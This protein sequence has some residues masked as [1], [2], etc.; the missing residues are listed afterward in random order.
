M[1]NLDL[2]VLRSFVTGL[3]LGSFAKAAGRLGRSTSAISAQLK[4]L[5]EQIGSPVLQKSGR[6]LRLTPAGEVLLSYARRLLELND[7][8][9]LAVRGTQLNG[10]VRI[11]FQE[12][13]GA[14]ILTDV[15]GQF[16]KTHPSVSIEARIARNLE[17]ETAIQ[18]DQLDLALAWQTTH[19]AQHPVLG[20][21]PL[22]WLGDP[23][24]VET[25][26][27]QRQPI[28][29]VAFEAPCLM[30][31]LAIDALDQAGLSWRIAFTSTSLNGIWSAVQAGLG[32]TVRSLAGKPAELARIA[33]LPSL[34]DLGVCLLRSRPESNPA[35]ERLADIVQ[36]RIRDFW[37]EAPQKSSQR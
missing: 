26:L 6:G 14:G 10:Q 3:D 33:R 5:E 20:R 31:N 8:A 22:Y 2:D 4:K 37:L 24:L 11:G 21:L 1:R 29:L 23:T 18:L 28:P 15:L 36:M 25:C 16:A 32:V 19:M 13:F 35:L 7:T 27:Q 9:L 12:D 17:L 34:P 30:R